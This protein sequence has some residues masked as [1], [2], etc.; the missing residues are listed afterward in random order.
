MSTP[1]VPKMTAH[2]RRVEEKG[3]IFYPGVKFL[4]ERP[5]LSTKLVK[6]V[7]E[8]GLICTFD[9]LGRPIMPK[10]T[11]RSYVKAIMDVFLPAGYP[12]TVTPDYTPYQIYDSLQAFSSTI[13]GLLSSRAVLQG[14][15]VG[16]SASSA[17]AAVLLT[18]L[19][20]ATGR[21]ATILFAH[22]HGRAIEPECKFYR[23]L[24]DIVNDSAL[25]LD[26]LSPALPTYPKVI[27]LCGAGI[28]RALCGVAGGAAKASLSAHFAKN[29]NLAE[30]NAKDGSQETVIS[31]FGMLV[32][33]LFVQ[34]V[35]GKV[36]VW[37]WMV[38][39][40]GLHLW[41]N[42]K[43]VT[44]VQMRTLNKQR[45]IIVTEAYLSDDKTILRPDQVAAREG[46][47][48]CVPQIKNSTHACFARKPSDIHLIKKVDRERFSSEEYIIVRA[49]DIMPTVSMI[50]MKE[51]ASTKL[52]LEAWIEGS[53]SRQVHP[54][55]W[56][57]LK[58]AGWDLETNALETG[59]SIRLVEEVKEE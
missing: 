18:V 47:L 31:L 37:T 17:T 57:G 7:D 55:F 3:H 9:D 10:K 27:A 40:V 25:F 20:E 11:A 4:A 21:L 41:T 34:F 43:A 45:M 2:R 8:S 15:G 19:Q 53:Y 6:V 28:L 49:Q 38:I 51:H 56:A 13:A 54:R 14:F 59:P 12:Y 46:I 1:E 35:H 39:L 26:V 52:M 30:L 29:G 33:S 36:A 23:F 5:G 58:N 42:Y 22:R 44:S 50:F 24:A 16:D 32:G 48:T